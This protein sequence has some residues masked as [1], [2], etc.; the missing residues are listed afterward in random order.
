MRIFADFPKIIT[1]FPFKYYK[2][3]FLGC[4]DFIARIDGKL[5]IIRGSNLFSRAWLKSWT[6]KWSG[7]RS[8]EWPE[9]LGKSEVNRKTAIK[10]KLAKQ[11]DNFRFRS[12]P[13][14]NPEEVFWA[15]RVRQFGCYRCF[16]VYFRFS[17]HFRS[18]GTFE[19][20]TILLF[21]SL[22]MR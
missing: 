18:P 8:S 7:F 16:P 4:A 2:D 21:N 6:T 11:T 12:L 3:G 19:S 14:V 17:G 20:W 13:P 10:A 5:S 15:Y 22:A 1:F 9:V